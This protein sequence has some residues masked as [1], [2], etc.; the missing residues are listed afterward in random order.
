[1][2][3]DFAAKNTSYTKVYSELKDIYD[4]I[5]NLS[6]TSYKSRKISVDADFLKGIIPNKKSSNTSLVRLG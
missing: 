3:N 5:A 6:I 2:T 4:L 1:L